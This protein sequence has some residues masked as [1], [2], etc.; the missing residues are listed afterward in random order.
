MAASSVAI[1][2]C[3]PTVSMSRMPELLGCCISAM[4][5]V[6]INYKEPSKSKAHTVVLMTLTVPG[7]A[8]ATHTVLG[9]TAFMHVMEPSSFSCW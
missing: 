3:S 7:R 2:V 9:E 4:L 5:P 8:H 1:H 6:Y